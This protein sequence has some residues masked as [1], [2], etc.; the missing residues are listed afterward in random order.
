[1]L[2]N[3]KVYVKQNLNPYDLTIGAILFN[4]Q[5]DIPVVN[6]GLNIQGLNGERGKSSLIEFGRK[7]DILARQQGSNY[8]FYYANFYRDNSNA[9]YDNY[10]GRNFD[11]KDYIKLYRGADGNDYYAKANGGCRGE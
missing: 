4:E 9:N 6:L 2:P 10:Y 7:E 5:G 1:M 11:E 8:I 3:L